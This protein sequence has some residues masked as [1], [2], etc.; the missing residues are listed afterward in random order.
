MNDTVVLNREE[1][2]LLRDG[3]AFL[4]AENEELKEKLAASVETEDI[5]LDLSGIRALLEAKKPPTDD[6]ILSSVEEVETEDDD[7]IP[8]LSDIMVNRS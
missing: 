3:F 7:D 6:E 8:N 2:E 4:R 1:F 5:G